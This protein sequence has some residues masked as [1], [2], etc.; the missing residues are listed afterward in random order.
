MSFLSNHSALYRSICFAALL[1]LLSGCAVGPDYMRPAVEMPGR[2][3]RAE[4]SAEA[5]IFDPLIGQETKFWDSFG[6][7][8]LSSL[9]R[10][11][12][13]ANQDL[14]QALARFDAADALLT[15]ARLD[16]FPT[17]TA[18]ANLGHQTLSREEARG[19]SR[20]TPLSNASVNA[21]WELDLFGR[22]RRNTEAQQAE[23]TASAADVRAVRVLI[24]GE[25][26]Q[27]YMELRGA[28]ER[29]RVAREQADN[30][31]QTLVI[32]EARLAAGRGSEL[33]RVRARSLY[34]S[35]ASRLAAFEAIIGVSQHR[36][37]VLLGQTPAA[38]IA[39][40]DVVTP[41]PAAPSSIDAGAPG[42]LLRRRPDIAAAEARLH[43]ATARVG[44]A[45]AGLFPRFTLSGLIGTSTGSY[46]FFR[47]GSDTN[48]IALGVDWS[49]LDVGRVRAR[50]AA[51]DADAAGSLASYQQTVLRAVEET[52]NALLRLSR[53]GEESFR[54]S[55]AAAD[56][57][58][59]SALARSRFLAGAIDF[60]QVLDVERSGLLA[61]DAEVDARTRRTLAAVALYKALAGGWPEGEGLGG[62]T[63]AI[64]D[65]V[66]QVSWGGR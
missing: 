12:Y 50:I 35:T 36:I 37:A 42:D 52:E 51:S 9:I 11:A 44:I 38:L 16:R 28:Q 8:M 54:L 23:L 65:H 33:D 19:A 64:D 27:T 45:T 14:R 32:V 7:P 46:G 29:L 39:E 4:P 1:G 17:V 26:A 48:L 47:D 21:S 40:L 60:H 3:A 43:A 66:R 22:V 30:Q 25:I 34:E 18:G 6:D 13:E 10:R 15:N 56:S 63:P 41:L 5:G 53:T 55:R 20:S 58:L 24:A 59:A 57:T 61:Q 31:Q 2:F 62:A 49:F